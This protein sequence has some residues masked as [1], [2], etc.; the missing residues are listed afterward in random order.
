[1][2][3]ES[4]IQQRN[5]DLRTLSAQIIASTKNVQYMSRQTILDIMQEQSA[6]RFYLSPY[7]ASLYILRAY[8]DNN[9]NCRKQDMIADLLENYERLRRLFPEAKKI[10]LYEMLV[11]Q[12]AKSFYLSSKRMREIIFNYTGR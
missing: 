6:P 9:K 8:H 11:E 3:I 12:P 4:L 1:M 7:Q 2:K 5:S 10:V